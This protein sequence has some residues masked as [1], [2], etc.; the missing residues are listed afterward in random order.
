MKCSASMS[1][2]AGFAQ[3]G[4]YFGIWS[5]S[6][7]LHRLRTRSIY[8]LHRSDLPHASRETQLLLF[9]SI[10]RGDNFSNSSL[11]RWKAAD[12]RQVTS[13]TLIACGRIPVCSSF[14][15]GL[16][17]AW[18]FFLSAQVGS[19]N[20]FVIAIFTVRRIPL[21]LNMDTLPRSRCKRDDR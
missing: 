6:T 5:Q 20:K 12:I 18:T 9:E 2:L 21:L 14:P 1:N 8:D 4:L 13:K 17:P 10:C 16:D 7:R 15:G 11:P 3:L 19:F